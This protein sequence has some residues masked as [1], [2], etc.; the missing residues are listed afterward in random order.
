MFELLD[1]PR[2]TIPYSWQRRAYVAASAAYWMVIAL[3]ARTILQPS[4]ALP[5]ILRILLGAV[6]FVLP[7]L[8]IRN[9]WRYRSL[10]A[11]YK[12]MSPDT[13]AT[14]QRVG[15]AIEQVTRQLFKVYNPLMLAV[16]AFRLFT[17]Y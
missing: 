17:R 11:E 12:S 1:Q 16:M 3:T 6:V 2:L 9:Y 5:Q 7:F 4:V 14:D 15:F 10:R 13:R 8:W